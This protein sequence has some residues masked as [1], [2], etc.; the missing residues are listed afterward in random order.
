MA[1]QLPPQVQA[2]LLW[3]KSNLIVVV[4]TAIVV[5][6]PVGSYFAAEKFRAGIESEAKKRVTV[7]NDLKSTVDAR[8]ALPLPGGEEF[9]LPGLP[10]EATVNEYQGILTKVSADAQAVYAKARDFNRGR[11]ALAEDRAI[12][13]ESIFPGYKRSQRTE[14]ESVRLKFADALQQRYANLIA[15][16]RAGRPPE[17]SAVASAVSAA[18]KRIVQGQLKQ[19]SRA[20]LDAEQTA[21]LDRQL[22]RARVEQYFETAKKISFYLDPQAFSIPTRA[23]A[24]QALGGRADSPE[25]LDRQDATLFRWQWNYWIVSD[26]LRAFAAANASTPAV[27]KAPVKR[28]IRIESALPKLEGK[29]GE[30]DGSSS[31]LAGSGGS[32]V[33]TEPPAD[34]GAMGEGSAAT[35]AAGNS[36]P[37][38]QLGTPMVDPK[39]AATRNFA[40]SLT[41]RVSNPVYDVVVTQVTFIA[42]TAE[43]PKVFDAIAAQNLMT[44]TDV[45]VAP[46]DPFAD[47]RLGYLYGPE[48]VSLVTATIE[49][50]WLREWTA[51]F[52]PAV[53]RTAL[54]IQSA[55]PG[56]AEGGEAPAQ[57]GME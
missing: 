12:V 26:V 52:M 5:V 44:V 11:G 42:E 37:D 45:K 14:R 25:A 51:T 19:E 17:A 15:S 40:G 54:G 22:G 47:A 6:V 23:E 56:G 7:F 13:P 10:N 27:V 8:V 36:V 49:T 41:G 30:G 20:K 33:P 9:P 48:P 34:G 32:D 18:E 46:A 16:C 53:V 50:I 28:V 55:Q 31:G 35:A 29:G 39:A 1:K 21:A 57:M 2:A 38:V 24:N 3:V 43:L 4:F